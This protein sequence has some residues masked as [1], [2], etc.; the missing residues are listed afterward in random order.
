MA[1]ALPTRKIARTRLPVDTELVWLPITTLP[2][3]DETSCGP[4]CLHAVYA[5]WGDEEPLDAVIK[6]MHW[7]DEGG[8]FAVFLGCD[9]LRRGYRARIYTYNLTV[10]DPS[11]FTQPRVDLRERLT[12]QRLAKE[13]RRLHSA[14][15]GYLDFLNLGGRIRLANLSQ[16]LVGGILRR[17]LP[18][19]TGLSSTYLYQA[20]REYGP[21]DE[22]D[23]IRGRPQGHFVVI[24]GWNRA[25]RK[26][27][28][29][30]PYQPH[31]YGPALQ[32][33]LGIDRVITA[34]LL[35]IVTHDANLLVIYPPHD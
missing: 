10:F 22:P 19:L 35:G 29:V 4:T 5:Y 30:D 26:V 2:Q 23:D 17:R 18:L 12:R 25:K 11:W 32:Y 3:P 24:A 27:L 20:K 28:V 9:A 21:T 14:T 31:R 1:E 7:L 15:E 34:I 6:R 16:H 33:W 13:D 8:T